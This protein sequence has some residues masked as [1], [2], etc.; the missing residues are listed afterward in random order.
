[1]IDLS[2]LDNVVWIAS[3]ESS[4]FQDIHNFRSS[5]DFLVQV[6]LIFLEPDLSSQRDRC[7]I[8]RKSVVTVVED[9]LNISNHSPLTGSF[10]KHRLSDI[11]FEVRV[12][13]RE[14]KLNC[15]EEVALPRTISS[16][17]NVVVFTEG[18]DNRL[19]S[20]TSESL[21]DDLC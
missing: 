8:D 5:D 15:K 3:R 6:V 14:N 19:L 16:Y 2:L 7:V 9:D 20:I 12:F 11:G 4:R 21:D 10:V 13:I 18:I 1:M 17:D